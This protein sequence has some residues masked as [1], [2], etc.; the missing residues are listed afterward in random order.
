MNK[1][2]H[3]DTIIAWANGAPIE[4]KDAVA[5]TW[6][7]VQTPSWYESLNYRIKPEPVRDVLR[8]AYI[9]NSLS[10]GPMMYAVQKSIESNITMVFD[11]TTGELKDVS[12]KQ[13]QKP[14]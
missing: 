14:F 3:Y 13:P 10:A 2:K 8:D 4:M 1:H 9:V 11:G 6:H 5:D 7:D 12:F